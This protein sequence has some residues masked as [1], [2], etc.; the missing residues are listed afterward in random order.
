MSQKLNVTK[1]KYHLKISITIT[2]I[3]QK[4]IYHKKLKRHKDINVTK[5][6]M[7]QKLKSHQLKYH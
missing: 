5:T 1:L 6:E 7:S 4:P 2:D 3:S